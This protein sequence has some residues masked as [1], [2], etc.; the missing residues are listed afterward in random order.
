MVRKH[1]FARLQFTH[2]RS[3]R[4]S[5]RAHIF[6]HPTLGPCSGFRQTRVVA[7]PDSDQATCFRTSVSY[8][9]KTWAL[10]THVVR[11]ESAGI[12]FEPEVSRVYGG[13]EDFNLESYLH[14][15]FWYCWLQTRMLDLLGRSACL[16]QRECDGMQ[17]FGFFCPK[18][19]LPWY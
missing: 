8:L 14:R 3:C 10:T 13:I 16:Q 12:Q 18:H 5:H 4:R 2:R 6:P 7:R 1:S 17:F 15:I 11:K 9:Q 19:F